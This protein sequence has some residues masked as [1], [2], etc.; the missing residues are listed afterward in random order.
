MRG[1]GPIGVFE[2]FREPCKGERWQSRG[3]ELAPE[4]QPEVTVR[5]DETHRYRDL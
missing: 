5:Q 2:T 3:F 4:Q 1:K